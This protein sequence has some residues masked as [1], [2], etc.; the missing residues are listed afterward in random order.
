MEIA[1]YGGFQK[2]KNLQSNVKDDP[3]GEMRKVESERDITHTRIVVD[4]DNI[5]G[6]YR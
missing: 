6:Q 5:N 2:K 3:N 1:F 4:T